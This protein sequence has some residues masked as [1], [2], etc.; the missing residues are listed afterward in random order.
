[1][2]R[3]TK[4]ASMSSGTRLHLL[5]GAMVVS[6][7]G[8]SPAYA[9]KAASLS[10]DTGSARTEVAGK[11]ERVELDAPVRI[12]IG[13]HT[14]EPGAARYPVRTNVAGSG[15]MVSFSKTPVTVSTSS[16]SATAPFA[17]LPGQLPIGGRLTS[18]FGMRAHPISGGVRLHSGVDLAAP[19]GS[20][21]RATA[22]GRVQTAG[23]AGGYGYMV[24]TR[25]ADGVEARY[26]H[27]SGIAVAPGQEVKEGDVVGYVGSTGN[28][29]GPHV[30]YEVRLNGVA[31]N[32]LGR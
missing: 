2:E 22:S 8:A 24:S 15:L 14:V 28:S 16:T 20:P 11:A 30:H 32:P 9:E 13:A 29:T 18:G 10:A 17:G 6:A 5:L 1:M 25:R 23:W 26:A 12:T 31:V 21:V 3:L 19:H 7:V 27:L 4:G